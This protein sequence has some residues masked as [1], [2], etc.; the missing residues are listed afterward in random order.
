MVV[1]K[2]STHKVLHCNINNVTPH[3]YGHEKDG[4]LSE[5]WTQ[6]RTELSWIGF[7]VWRQIAGKTESTKL[8]IQHIAQL[9][10]HDAKDDLNDRIVKVWIFTSFTNISRSRVNSYLLSQTFQGQGLI[11]C[12]AI[13]FLHTVVHFESRFS[14]ILLE[15][16]TNTHS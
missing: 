2:L 1:V 3:F 16:S 12:R 5:P 8:M 6:P 13:I 9:C 11:A 4:R 14:V 10:R 15:F 7:G